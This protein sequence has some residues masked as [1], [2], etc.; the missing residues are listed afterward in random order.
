[1]AVVNLTIRTINAVELIVSLN[2][3]HKKNILPYRN[4]IISV[5]LIY[6]IGQLKIEYSIFHINYFYWLIIATLWQKQQ[7]QFEYDSDVK[8]N[9]GIHLSNVQF[10]RVKLKMYSFK[11]TSWNFTKFH[12]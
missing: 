7:H 10:L 4:D 6:I 8:Q 9:T 5:S 2:A 12:I 11:T 3:L 1:M